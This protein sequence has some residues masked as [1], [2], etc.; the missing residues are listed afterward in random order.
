MLTPLVNKLKLV[1]P[2]P[3]WEIL[4][5]PALAASKVIEPVNLTMSVLVGIVPTVLTVTPVES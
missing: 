3:V 5:A 1:V 2:N 4:V